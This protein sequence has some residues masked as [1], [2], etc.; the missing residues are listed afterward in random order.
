MLIHILFAIFVDLYIFPREYQLR[1]TRKDGEELNAPFNGV[2]NSV[3]SESVNALD[4]VGLTYRTRY[5]L[6]NNDS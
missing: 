2:T 1:E 3:R 5:N 6:V 4:S